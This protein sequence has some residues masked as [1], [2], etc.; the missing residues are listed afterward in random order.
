MDAQTDNKMES[1]LNHTLKF[2]QPVE[3]T[4][5]RIHDILT[6]AVEGGCNYWLTVNA[7]EVRAEAE[8]FDGETNIQNQIMLGGTLNCYDAE[9]AEDYDKLGELTLVKIIE[10]LIAMSCGE[11]LKF[12]KN[13]HLKTHFN[14]FITEN[15]DCETADV[16]I[17]IA[18][19]G[20][21]V[22]G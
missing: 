16:I 2:N 8:K 13:E 5:E 12:N 17:Q 10:A 11:D 21:I 7:D 19:M 20:E 3:I 9:N 15:D 1:I 22:F 18:C 6:S 14:N 4:Q